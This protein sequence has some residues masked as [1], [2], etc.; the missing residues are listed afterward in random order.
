[1]PIHAVIFD[2][3]GVLLDS[4]ALCV[5]VERE[6]LRSLGCALDVETY[7]T[8]FVGLSEEAANAIL[9]QEFNITLPP[10]FWQH[11][12]ATMDGV[13]ERELRAMPGCEQLL[14]A[15]TSPRCVASSSSSRRLAH[16]L[17]LTNLLRFF[18]ERVFSA[19][20]VTRGKPHPDLF[21]Y[22]ADRLDAQP[23]RCVVV[24][25]SPAGVLAAHAAGMRVIGFAGGSHITPAGLARLAHT[26]PE[27]IVHHMEELLPLLC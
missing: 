3:D 16:T 19:Q 26:G 5:Q 12:A 1:M 17:G 2:C 14:E 11:V 13:F 9:A 20:M 22:A 21:L 15:L 24:E 23:E 18:P 25:D 8:R 6:A 7:M 10:A 4:E 27:T